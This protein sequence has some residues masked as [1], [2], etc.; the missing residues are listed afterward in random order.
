MAS[1]ATKPGMNYGFDRVL[2]GEQFTEV[3]RPLPPRALRHAPVQRH[4]RQGQERS[5]SS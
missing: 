2:H 5:L 3:K 1:A 4:L